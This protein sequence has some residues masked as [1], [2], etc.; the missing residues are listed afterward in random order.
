[1]RPQRK[2]DE[3]R[4]RLCRYTWP[5]A[6]AATRLYRNRYLL[7]E[8]AKPE[9][10]PLDLLRPTIP[11]DRQAAM[12]TQIYSCVRDYESNRLLLIERD[13]VDRKRG[14]RREIE[15]EVL[16]SFL[17]AVFYQNTELEIKQSWDVETHVLTDFE[18][19]LGYI[20][21]QL[22]VTA[23][24]A[25]RE[26]IASHR[27]LKDQAQRLSQLPEDLQGVVQQHVREGGD[28]DPVYKAMEKA[29]RKM[30][31]ARNLAP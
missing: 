22:R 24:T 7:D 18:Q 29:I 27:G 13:R 28:F 14:A 17:A 23:P 26:R 3:Q 10:V 20:F 9:D 16:A 6:L 31:K 25:A 2:K 5:D 1:M 19:F 30:K 8:A 12:A 11:I 15:L 4:Q 21:R